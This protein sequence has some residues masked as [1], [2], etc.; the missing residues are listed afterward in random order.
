MYT[1][2]QIEEIAESILYIQKIYTRLFKVSPILRLRA[3]IINYDLYQFWILEPNHLIILLRLI[4][5][6]HKKYPEAYP[7]YIKGAIDIINDLKFHIPEIYW[8]LGYLTKTYEVI[9]EDLSWDIE[10]NEDLIKDK[11][12]T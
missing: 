12:D 2:N 5:K 9:L 4:F 11:N 8:Q 10:L 3:D 6:V 1:S 7:F